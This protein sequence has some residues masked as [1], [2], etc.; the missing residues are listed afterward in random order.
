MV[1]IRP[2]TQPEE[3]GMG[4]F[5]SAYLSPQPPDFGFLQVLTKLVFA[6]AAIRWRGASV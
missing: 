6:L 3:E 1:W 5:S 2:F 4:L